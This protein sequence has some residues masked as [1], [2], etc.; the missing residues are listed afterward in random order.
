MTSI[1]IPVSEELQKALDGL[2]CD[3]LQIPMPTPLQVRLPTGG[4]LKAFNDISKGIPNDCSMVFNLLLQIAP[5]LASMECLLKILKVLDPLLKVVTGLTK[6][7]PAPP[8]DALA[9]LP[10]AVADLLPCFAMFANIP[11]FAKDILCLIRAVLKCLL[12]Q[13]K[14][15]RDLMS[16]LELSLAAA[17]GNADQLAAIQCAQKNAQAAAQNL[18]QAIDPISGI[19]AVAGAVMSIAGLPPIE[20]K[21]PSAPPEDLAA[22]DAMVATLQGVVDAIDEVT[23]GICGA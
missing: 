9:K 23:G 20:L 16:G 15:V 12:A 4:S 13:L 17:E 3:A 19:L 14:S 6:L 21:A 2:P 10:G 22:L 11:L 1:D 5:L 8:A 7:P 18:T